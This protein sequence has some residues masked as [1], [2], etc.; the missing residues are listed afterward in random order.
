MVEHPLGMHEVAGSISDRT[1]PKTYKMVPA[2]FLVWRL[3]SGSAGFFAHTHPECEV[4][5]D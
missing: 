1:I 3:T 4:E 5:R 2:N